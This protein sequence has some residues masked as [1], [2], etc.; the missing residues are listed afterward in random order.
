MVAGQPGDRSHLWGPRRSLDRCRCGR[1]GRRF[2]GSRTHWRSSVWSYAMSA[3]SLAGR[4]LHGPRHDRTVGMAATSGR[5]AS[6][7][8]CRQPRSP[9]SEEFLHGRQHVD[10]RSGLASIDRARLGHGAPLFFA[11]TD[12]A[13][14][15]ARHQL[16]KPSL[17]SSSRTVRCSRRHRPA[18]VQTVNRR[19]A[20]GTVTPNDGGSI[21]H[22]QPLVST[23]TTA[24]N[25]ARSST[26]AVPP[27]WA[28]GSNL[29]N[30]GS[31]SAHNPS[32]TRR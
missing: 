21:R 32:G 8:L 19:C 29:G 14:I 15:T 4:R 2:P 28:R 20:V 5:S 22:A 7:S 26:G 23:N 3:C 17:P 31:T 9:W 12:A 30:K 25:T 18:S 11:R 10:L 16:M 27:P 1:S 6:A 13:S 24:V